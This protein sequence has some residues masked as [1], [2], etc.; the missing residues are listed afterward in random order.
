M[1]D[2]CRSHVCAAAGASIPM[3]PGGHV[4]PI[5]MKGDVHGNVPPPIF[6]GLFFQ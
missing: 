4:P 6:V 2:K 1:A 3:G 5:F